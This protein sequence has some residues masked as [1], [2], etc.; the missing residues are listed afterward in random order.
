MSSIG[1]IR[2]GLTWAC[3]KQASL[4]A[5]MGY[6]SNVLT[7]DFN[8]RYPIIRRELVAT[9]KMHENVKI[10]NIYEYFEGIDHTENFILPKKVSLTELAEDGSLDKRKGHNAYRVYKNGMYIKYLA[11]HKDGSLHF[12][13]YFNEN[14]HRTMREEYAPSGIIKK[15][16]YMDLYLNKPRQLIF[17]NNE[18]KAYISQ[19][20]NPETNKIQRINLFNANGTIKKVFVNE[21]EALK[22]YWIEEIINNDPNQDCIVVS[23]TRTTDET[24]VKFNHPKAVKIWRLHSSHTGNPQK[25]DAGIREKVKY[26]FNHMDKFNINLFLTEEQK[27]DIT[28][29]IGTDLNFHVIPHYHEV[30]KEPFSRL[31]FREK[32]NEKV[33]VIVSRFSTLK[34]IDHS[35]K[36]FQ[37][38]TKELPDVRLE[39][40]GTGDQ[41]TYLKQLIKELDLEK[42]VLIK[43]YT[44][45]PDKIYKSGLFSILTS[46]NEGFSLSILESMTNETPVISYDIKYGPRDM[47]V[48]EEN[49]YLI[50]NGNI[51]QLATKM[52]FLFKNPDIAIKMGKQAGKYVNE[53]FSKE[54]YR[55]K[56]LKVIDLALNN[57]DDK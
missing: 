16:T 7:F 44:R 57:N 8:P 31:F 39:I 34:R 52:I 53:N 15:K 38:V 56:W 47:I 24:C 14:R 51:E 4:F 1:L 29:R 41:E 18:G 49:G 6:N 26:G 21:N 42:N 35:I 19:W 37:I 46:K 11:L 54:S 28:D 3:L 12:I 13:D 22:A 10:R 5:E 20:N 32:K 50:E 55:K 40:W 17:Y 30:K 36:A 25:L 27:K 43:G 9:G 33:C 45:K 2:G 23:D 48:N